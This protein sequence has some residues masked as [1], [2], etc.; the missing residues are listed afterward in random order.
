MLP[1]PATLLE[2]FWTLLGITFANAFSKVGNNGMGVDEY[3]KEN[4]KFKGVSKYLVY[5]S[6]N[7]LHH[8]EIGG[9][10]IIYPM[11]FIELKW[12]GLG[13]MIDDGAFELYKPLKKLR[14]YKLSKPETIV[15]G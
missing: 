9:L 8:W 12:I 1:V 3:I 4:G 11:P 15:S 13:L 14:E 6:L 2:I 10:L 5:S 7:F